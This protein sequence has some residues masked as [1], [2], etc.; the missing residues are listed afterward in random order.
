VTRSIVALVAAS[1][2]T[3]AAGAAVAA[4]ATPRL[5]YAVSAPHATVTTGAITVPASSVLSWFTDRPQRRAGRGTVRDVVAG[6]SANGFDSDPPNAAVVGTR[7]GEQVQAVVEL[8]RPVLARGRVTFRY[9]VVPGGGVLGMDGASALTPGRHGRTS[10]FIDEAVVPPCPDMVS[11][12]TTCVAAAG[13]SVWV[14][15]E[16]GTSFSVSACA[17]GPRAAGAYHDAMVTTVH[18][19]RQTS[20]FRA[21]PVD[22][23]SCPGTTPI[24]TSY[25]YGTGR[26][27]LLAFTFDASA[28]ITLTA[29]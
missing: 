22:V 20:D 16:R 27:P 14:R 1:T 10:L 18:Y 19:P 12:P 29:S 21:R 25:D 9:T 6:W 3:L 2:A 8:R 4:P 5:L 28:P 11:A 17:T 24:L 15:A 13:S 23:A 26:G 7:G